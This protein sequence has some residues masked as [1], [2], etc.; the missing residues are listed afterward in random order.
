MTSSSP[1][2]YGLR[3]PWSILVAN[4]GAKVGPPSP[5][6]RA[7][8]CRKGQVSGSANPVPSQDGDSI[9][10]AW[11]APDPWHFSQTTQSSGGGTP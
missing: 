2:A 9:L 6:T 4:D 8:P 5:P 7:R 10:S 11:L 1:P 3:P